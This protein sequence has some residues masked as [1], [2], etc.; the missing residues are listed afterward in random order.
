MLKKIF[1]NC[2][3]FGMFAFILSV[4]CEAQEPV[5]MVLNTQGD[6]QLLEPGQ[7]TF[8]SG[9]VADFVFPESQIQ[10]GK[11]SQVE[12]I[13][14]FEACYRL[15]IGEN[16]LIF[17]TDREWQIKQGAVLN[18][19]TIEHCYRPGH[20]SVEMGTVPG[21]TVL[22]TEGTPVIT[23][24]F[25]SSTMLID[26]Y[27]EFRW[28]PLSE[29][30]GYRLT[31]YRLSPDKQ[32]R[33]LI[34]Q[35]NVPENTGVFPKSPL[36]VERGQRYEWTVETLQEETVT[37]KGFGMFEVLDEET[38]ARVTDGRLAYGQDRSLSEDSA[39]HLMLAL[40]YESLGAW[41]DALAEYQSVRLSFPDSP[42]LLRSIAFLYETVGLDEEAQKTW[43]VVDQLE[44]ERNNQ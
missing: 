4:F 18:E 44:K 13:L 19:E 33:T 2:L 27:P 12:I 32:A 39:S 36:P 17:V 1:P 14:F 3:F 26:L 28:T 24:L 35:I 34:W 30:S 37:G 9:S 16:S 31:L 21:G 10:T 41:G 42:A 40:F 23:G 20:M 5:G 38:M 29:K 7:Q 25:P 15:E 43:V 22:R 8:R 11:E 6:V